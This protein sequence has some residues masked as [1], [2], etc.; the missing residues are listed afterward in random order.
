MEDYW[1][2]GVFFLALVKKKH[3]LESRGDEE[4][5]PPQLTNTDGRFETYTGKNID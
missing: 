4:Q 5:L 2:H 1:L 3:D